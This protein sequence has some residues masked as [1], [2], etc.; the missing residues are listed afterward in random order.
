MLHKAMGMAKAYFDFVSSVVYYY[1]AYFN[2]SK[3]DTCT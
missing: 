3:Y 2:L 1:Y